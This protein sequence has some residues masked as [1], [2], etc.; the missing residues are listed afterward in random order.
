MF[1]YTELVSFVSDLCS[2]NLPHFKVM[3]EL[4]HVL[5]TAT[6][7][8]HGSLSHLFEDTVTVPALNFPAL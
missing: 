4:E 5:F 3:A 8:G 1:E 2:F 6:L 7:S